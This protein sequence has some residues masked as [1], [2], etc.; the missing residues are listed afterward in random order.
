M[1]PLIEL[2]QVSF[3]Y[4]ATPVLENINLHLHAGQFAALVGPSGAGK[5]TLLK[6]VLGVLAPTRGKLQTHV[7]V[8]VSPALGDRPR[9]HVQIGYIPQLESVDLNFPVTVEQVVLMGCTRDQARPHAQWLPWHGRKDREKLQQVLQQLEIEPLAKRHIRD[10]SGG[11][12]QRVFLAR[13][14]ISKPDILVLDEPTS[15]VDVRTAQNVM[16]Q[17]ADLNRTGM[18]V[19]MTTHDLNLAAAH[20]PWVIALN[21][22]VLAEGTPDDVFTEPILNKTYN[23]DMLVIRQGSHIFIQE[24]PHGHSWRDLVPE[25]VLGHA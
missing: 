23:A 4:G 13:A 19:L 25:P 2:H 12:L 11:Q 3:G 16:H 22:S 20:V 15:G 6:L 17:I 24:R 5:S 18:T 8:A 14:L 1:Q 9:A 21:R 10:L 7:Q